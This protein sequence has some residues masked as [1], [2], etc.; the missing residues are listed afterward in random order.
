MAAPS[1]EAINNAMLAAIH[2]SLDC[3]RDFVNS[4][5]DDELIV[6]PD[7]SPN[8][9]QIRKMFSHPVWLWIIDDEARLAEFNDLADEVGELDAFY[10]MGK[11]KEPT[12]PDQIEAMLN[13]ED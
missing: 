9:T 1:Q 2:S 7:F 12:S 8:H 10:K 3:D 5:T 4:L 6:E 11:D 13:L